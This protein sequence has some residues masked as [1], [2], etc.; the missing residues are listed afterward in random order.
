MFLK[1]NVIKII[2]TL[3]TIL[4]RKREKEEMGRNKN[5]MLKLPNKV[6]IIIL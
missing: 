2:P 3:I 1:E 4:K 5:N 6:P